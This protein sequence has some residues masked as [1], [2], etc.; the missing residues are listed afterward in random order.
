MLAQIPKCGD[1]WQKPCSSAIACQAPLSFREFRGKKRV[2]T[3]VHSVESKD[4]STRESAISL[5]VNVKA[6]VPSF[7]EQPQ[8]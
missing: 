4:F 7:L 8:R 3:D 5:H 2:V 6:E 1:T